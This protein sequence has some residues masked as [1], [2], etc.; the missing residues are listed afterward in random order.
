MSLSNKKLNALRS[1]QTVWRVWGHAHLNGSIQVSAE[2]YIILGKKVT[3]VFSAGEEFVWTSLKMV[4]ARPEPD[5]LTA[6]W[7]NREYRARFLSDLHGLGCFLSARAAQR[8]ANEI[9]AGLH[10]E[11]TDYLVRNLEEDEAMSSWP[12]EDAYYP[13]EDCLTDDVPF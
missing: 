9:N 3:H 2:R 10:T 1:G 4:C 5:F 6:G 11:I 12:A 13:A 7:K 8:F